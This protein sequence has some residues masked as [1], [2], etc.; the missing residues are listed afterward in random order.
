MAA[1]EPDLNLHRRP[2]SR[3][4]GSEPFA[5]R[6]LFQQN[7]P[8]VQERVEKEIEPTRSFTAI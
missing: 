7:R 4:G 2:L 5:E 8:D 6:H 3:F 1:R